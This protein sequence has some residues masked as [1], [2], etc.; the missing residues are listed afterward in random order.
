MNRIEF[1]NQLRALLTD[2]PTNEREEAL[3]YYENYFEDAGE[4]NEARII[5]E[6]GSPGRLSAIIRDEVYDGGSSFE[7]RAKDETNVKSS[8]S[9]SKKQVGENAQED[10]VNQSPSIPYEER[11][12]NA[13]EKSEEKRKNNTERVILIVL[14]CILGFPAVI[15]FGSSLLGVMLGL[16]GAMFGCIVGGVFVVGAGIASCFTAPEVGVA[17]I[18]GGFVTIGIGLILLSVAL[19]IFGVLLPKFIRWIQR[20]LSGK[21][22]KETGKV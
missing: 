20:K 3:T 16:G 4:D 22:H 18:G 13:Q 9:E 6:F 5:R 21:E 8:G 19:L 11:V 10:G 14:L 1:M 17:M 15:G 7:E 2:L 12:K